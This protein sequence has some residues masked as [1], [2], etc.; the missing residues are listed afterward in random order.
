VV[1]RDPAVRSCGDAQGFRTVD[2][3]KLQVKNSGGQY[4]HYGHALHPE[5]ARRKS[6]NLARLWLQDAQLDQAPRRPP[7][8]YDRD[9]K[10]RRFTGTHPAVM[11]EIVAAADWTYTSRKPLIRLRREY[12]WED[13]ALLIQRF[14]GLTIGVHRNYRRID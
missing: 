7:E 8:F 14:T 9:Q 2:N 12:F 6:Q 10:V 13:I 1:R 3:Q 4:F 11:R 5:A